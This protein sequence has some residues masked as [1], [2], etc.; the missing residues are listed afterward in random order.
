MNYANPQF[1]VSNPA[2]RAAVC[3]VLDTSGSMKGQPIEALNRGYRNFLDQIRNDDA[4]A[5]S[6]DLM[7]VDLKSAPTIAHAFGPIE[8]YPTEPEPFVASGGTGTDT[9]LRLALD[10]IDERIR[11]FRR[12]GVGVLRPWLVILQDGRPSNMSR[13]M[14]VVEEICVRRDANQLNYLCVGT[15]DHV[16]WEQLNQLSGNDAMALEGLDF[17]EFFSWLSK[18]LHQVSSAG[19]DGQ[20]SVFFSSTASWARQRN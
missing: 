9:A 19:V 15:G 8:S 10:S 2:D 1:D 5:M 17:S 7:V 3:I 18:S 11:M 6:V 20:D 14:K 16:N 13:T 4:A 12:N